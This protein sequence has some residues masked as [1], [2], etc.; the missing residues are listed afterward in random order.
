MTKD[1]PN[2]RRGTTAS[3]CL[4]Q[5]LAYAAVGL[6]PI[7]LKVQ[8]RKPL[9]RW[10]DLAS[11]DPDVVRRLFAKAFFAD[12]VAIVTGHGLFVI[13]ADRGHDGDVDGVAALARIAT[14]HGGLPP[15]PI[16]RTPRGGLHFY[17]SAP[18]GRVRNSAGVLARGV[19]VR[20]ERGM[21]LAPPS[22]GYEWEVS[23]LDVAVP[24]APNW[25]VSLVAPTPVRHR[26]PFGN[27]LIVAN[28]PAYVQTALDREVAKVANCQEGARMQTLN[29]VGFV[30]GGFVG[31]GLLDERLAIARLLEAATICGLVRD[32]GFE[33][34]ERS[35]LKA[36]ADGAAK[37]P[38]S[39]PVGV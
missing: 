16:C 4:E 31:T 9:K 20:G 30:I 11:V 18:I 13:D 19:D 22:A 12:G 28:V 25:L 1:I 5:A 26:M 38:R 32:D 23:P 6:R 8:S 39:L 29:R 10:P 7:P 17:F 2:F 21:A 15:G 34:V 27:S 33:R 37:N 3:K 14:E 24:A 36:L 35:I